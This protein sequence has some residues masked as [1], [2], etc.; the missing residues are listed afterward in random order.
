MRAP[1]PGA[2][3]ERL[4]RVL[5]PPGFRPLEE[6]GSLARH[7]LPARPDA[8]AQPALFRMW[9]HMLSAP[10]EIGEPVLESLPGAAPA[11]AL[12]TAGARACGP[13]RGLPRAKAAGVAA[14]EA[15]WSEN[16]SG[17]YITP[18]DG[19]RFTQVWGS[20]T[21][22][23]PALPA[24]MTADPTGPEHQCSVW[25]GLGGHRTHSRSLPQAGTTQA[26][27]MVGGEPE[28]ACW[29]WFQ[30]WVRD[31]VGLGPVNL[32]PADFPVRPGDAMI[33]CVAVEVG[34]VAAFHVKNQSTGRL[35]SLH[36]RA[37]DPSAPADGAAAE[38]IVERPS[39]FPPPAPPEEPPLHPL[40]DYG[41]VLFEGCAAETRRASGEGG[42]TPRDLTG[43]RLI[44]MSEA[45]MNPYRAALISRPA[46]LGAE[47]L[48]VSH[49][50]GELPRWRC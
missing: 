9:K 27:K 42:G 37:L 24:G 49:G 4:P 43:A 15:G 14:H 23:K 13:A 29:A 1:E 26:V 39:Q 33:C 8:G 28:A 32:S 17:A 46:K 35:R 30:W 47:K 22:P 12:A 6:T 5:P 34:N 20:W 50:G 3:F 36:F 10:L 48:L 41:T 45:R 16:W 11:C 25:V 38:W 19:E 21:V 2:A 40:P 7:G 44:G 31:G 18:R